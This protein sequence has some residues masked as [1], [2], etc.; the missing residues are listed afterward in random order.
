GTPFNGLVYTITQDKQGNIWVGTT[1]GLLI[2]SQAF[3]DPAAIEY[4]AC[5]FD[6]EDES[7]LANND[8][9]FI[10]CTPDNEI[11]V[12]TFG[13]GLNRVLN[14]GTLDEKPRFKSYTVRTGA[15]DDVILSIVDDLNGNL[16]ASVPP[17]T[18][19]LNPANICSG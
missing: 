13:G 17:H 18:Q 5:F 6:P 1:N 10:Y 2:F 9:H 3:T 16:W 15:P 19:T 11:Y 12:A 8:V 4:T 14:S 7:S